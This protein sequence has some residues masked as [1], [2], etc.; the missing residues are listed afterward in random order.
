MTRYKKL[1]HDSTNAFPA[2]KKLLTDSRLKVKERAAG[3]LGERAASFKEKGVA[4]LVLQTGTMADDEFKMWK[5]DAALPYPVSCL[6]GD[7]E[8]A[9]ATWGA[10][11]LPWLILTDKSHRVTAEGFDMDELD[12]KLKDLTK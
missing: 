2:L 3:L 7:A 9:R 12:A 6:K 1:Y 11:A 4:V 5:E 10:R 8:K